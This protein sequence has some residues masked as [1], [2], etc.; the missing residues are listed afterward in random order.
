MALA[1]NFDTVGSKEKKEKREI[2]RLT[3]LDRQDKNTIY[4]L[5]FAEP[6]AET[7]QKG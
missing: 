5:I 3:V 6:E 2:T 1:K 4:N 7:E